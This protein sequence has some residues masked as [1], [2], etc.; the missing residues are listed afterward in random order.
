[1]LP[2]FSI[3]NHLLIQ[4]SAKPTCCHI[5]AE[6]IHIFTQLWDEA[7]QPTNV[8]AVPYILST[9]MYTAC[10]YDSVLNENVSHSRTHPPTHTGSVIYP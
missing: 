6:L 7:A 9:I 1:M 4:I 5:T 3:W 10:A 2:L 8:Y